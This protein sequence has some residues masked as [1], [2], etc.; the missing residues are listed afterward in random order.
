MSAT[1]MRRPLADEVAAKLQDGVAQGRWPVGERI[2]SEPELMAE[3]GISRG[4]LREAI[5]ALARTGMFEVRRGDGTYVRA[6]NEI[7]GTAR[8][9]LPRAL[10]P[11][12]AAGSFC[13]RHP[14]GEARRPRGPMRTSS[15]FCARSWRNAMKRGRLGI[16]RPGRRPIG[17]S[18]WK[19]RAPPASR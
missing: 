19:W 2:P 11:G 6:T 14:I 7:S 18:I 8:P 4:T 3:F 9:D 16:S 5:K 15:S 12:R 10:G 1:P 17:S 13:P